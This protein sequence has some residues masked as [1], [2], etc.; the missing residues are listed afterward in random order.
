MSF[1]RDLISI[2]VPVYNQE[3][4]IGRCLKSILRQSYKAIEII[5]VN[6]G[7]TDNSLQII[8]SIAKKDSR[9]V[10]VDQEN[11]GEALARKHGYERAKGKWLMFVDHD[12]MLLPGAIE[13][14][15]RSIVRNNA[16][17]VCGNAL[18]RWGWI[19]R[20]LGC[21]PESMTNRIIDQTELFERYYVS[22]FGINLFP[23][24]LWGK[25]YRKKVVD[26]AMAAVDLFITPHLHFG[27]DEAFNLLLFPYLKRAFLIKDR[28]YLYRWGGLTSGFNR[29]LPELMDF[30]DFRIHLLDKYHYDKGYTTLF[31]EYVNILLSHMVQLIEYKQLEEKD[32]L[33]WLESELNNRYLVNRMRNYYLSNDTQV[34]DK[35][36]L[37]ILV[38]TK[39]LY[40]LAKHQIEQ[41]RLRVLGKRVLRILTK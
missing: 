21:A 22:F 40:S 30:S 20:Y 25:I 8:S 5:V 3:K 23:V 10:L 9:V 11:Q 39:G 29:H 36:R 31:I 41:Q 17:V 1:P 18:R 35:C 37:A 26:E 15:Y 34:P 38:D 7:S 12:D 6:D 14:L 28:V 24:T 27:G 4:Y 13:S 19:T 33:L 2:I 32:I 16:D